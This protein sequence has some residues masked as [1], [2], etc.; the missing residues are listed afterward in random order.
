MDKRKSRRKGSAGRPVTALLAGI[1]V[2]ALAAG[3]LL[4]RG[5]M[6]TLG[7][8]SSEALAAVRISE[9]QNHNVLTMKDANGDASAWIEIENTGDEPLSLHG[10][11]LTRDEKV[12]KTLVFPDVTL[13][14]GGFLL[15]YADGAT[16][17]MSAGKLHAPFRLPKSGS[18]A[19]YLFDPAGG[20]IDS[21]LVPSMAA[22]EAYAVNEDG[23][24]AVTERATPGAD[25]GA[26][27]EDRGEQI[28]DV[29]FSEVMTA[30]PG[31]FP[32]ARGAYH[33]YVELRNL[34]GRPVKL[35]NYGLTDNAAKPDKFRFPDVT[36]P[37]N[38]YLTIH[39][40]GGED[41]TDPAHLHAA[42][43]LSEGE[44]LRLT[45]PDGTLISTLTLP[46]LKSGQV[47]SWTEVDGWTT[48]IPPTPNMENTAESAIALDNQNA[49]RRR[50]NVYISEVMALPV[51]EKAD[52]V[53]LCNDTGMEVDLSGCGL[54]DQPGKPRRWQFPEG[55]RLAAGE[56]LAVF[57]TGSGAAAAGQLSAPCALTGA[58]G[59]AVCLSDRGGNRM[60]TL[61]LP[62]QYNGISYGRDEAGTCGYFET[63]TPLK[64][65][66]QALLPPAPGVE[67]SLP[68]GMHHSGETCSVALT[69]PA[70]GRIY[71][72]LD[73]S[74]PDM[75]KTPYTAPIEVSDTTILR[76]RVYMDGRLPSIMDTQSYLYNVNA[77]T[78][79]PYVVS[80]VSDPTGL[81]SDET[82]I[83]VPGPNAEDKFPHGDYNRGAN[84]WME[85]EREAHVE[86]FTGMGETAISQECGIK[87]HGRNT[88]AYELK[89]FKVMAKPC[90]GA[91][92]FRY[93]IFHERPWDE[94][95][96]FILRYSGQDYKSAF[97]RD[98]VMTNQASNTSVMYME[99]EECICYLNGKY[100]SAM[101]IRENISPFSLARREGWAGQEGSLDL[102]KSGYEEKQGSN[103]SYL[104][105]KEYLKTHDNATQETYEYIDKEV[106]I[107]NFIEFITMQV[108]Y[109]PPDTVNVK[110]YRNPDADGKWR[111]VIYDLDRALR[112]G[113]ESTDGFELMAQ[114]TNAQLFKA[115]MANP[116][117]RD[118]FLDYLNKAMSTFLSSQSLADAA[119]AQLARTKPLLGDYLQMMDL[120]EKKYREAFNNLLSNIK[121]RPALVLEHCAKYL[122]MTEDEIHARFPETLAAIEAYNSK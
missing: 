84:F 72:T 5:G 119:N 73:C 23:N 55:T 21:V 39:C 26:V 113:K 116:T 24:W 114:G 92:R 22:D 94:Y 13:E 8:E 111:W 29:A 59:E 62:A 77:A 2:L 57:L 83:M 70:G 12:N 20:M 93:P 47:C 46:A 105:L 51:A 52:W 82:G 33:D 120:T 68:G 38:G 32:D 25:N 90:Y 96:A 107:D 15:V 98:V 34:S 95:E 49:A 74:D 10:V 28:G 37:A 91:S 48:G 101:Y 27:F 121:T 19:L 69:A 87:L 53:E 76:T 85:W 109:G 54:S 97:M 75:S 115:F 100:Y 65:N 1:C 106:D 9:V 11:C 80:L 71:Y 45:Q 41:K 31:V 36:L 42:F 58:G 43:K 17:P 40:S 78:E 14:A 56:R 64:A 67:Y 44:T 118:R 30:N 86:V 89:C 99:S 81:Y 50:G 103:A 66:G 16:N 117:L 112:G 63:A 110:R 61:Y 102:V 7:A 122:H 79:A 88:R 18:T 60:D 6:A 4:D 35:K 108:V 3:W 104:A